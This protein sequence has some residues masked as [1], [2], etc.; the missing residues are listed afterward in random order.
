M[1]EWVGDQDNVI[2]NE[3]LDQQFGPLGVEP[4]DDVLEKNEQVHVA[5]LALTESEIFIF[6]LGAATSGLEALRRLVRRWHPLSGGTRR[7]LLPQSLVPDRCKVQ[8]LPTRLEKWEE[9]VRRYDRIKWSGTTTAALDEDIKTAA[10]E[11]P[12]PSEL[13]QHLAMNRARLIT[14]EQ[15]RSEI[16][17]HTEGRRS[18]FALQLWQR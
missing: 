3:A 1:I 17:A 14:Y 7:G 11:A 5:L 16:Q 2:T 9:L 15:V 12:V 13:E 8:D 6:V 10:L 18:Q 4:V